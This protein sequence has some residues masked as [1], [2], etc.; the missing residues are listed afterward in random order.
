[1]LA[2]GRLALRGT[3]RTGGGAR[4]ALGTAPT[5]TVAVPISEMLSGVGQVVFVD[6]PAS[7][8]AILAGLA[9]CDPS[10]ALAGAVGAAS[11]NAAAKV[12]GLDASATAAGLHGYNGCLVGCAFAAFGVAGL[13]LP[14]AAAL[15]GAATAPLAAVLGPAC[16]RVPQYT[17]AFNAT[18]LPVLAYARPFDAAA[19]VGAAPGVLDVLLCPLTGVGQIFVADSAV[20]GAAVLAGV[21]AR[22]PQ[23]AYLLLTIRRCVRSQCPRSRAVLRTTY[24]L[25][26][27]T[28]QC[29]A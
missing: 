11:G 14:V 7:G 26:L 9:I 10:L 27:T 25:L 12:L 18:A 29:L 19:D 20:A 22:S 3:V 16:G 2:V 5:T 6:K 15:G 28:F 17:L 21:A 24:H 13:G 23:C 4:R 8:G 1:M